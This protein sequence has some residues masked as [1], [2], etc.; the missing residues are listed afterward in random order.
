MFY[1]GELMAKPPTKNCTSTP[2]EKAYLFHVKE[3]QKEKFK[4]ALHT[5]LEALAKR[6]NFNSVRFMKM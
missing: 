5:S 3:G 2:P 6:P 1:L 4:E